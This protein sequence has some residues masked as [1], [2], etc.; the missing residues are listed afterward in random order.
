MMLDEII[1]YV[2][3]LQNQVEFL[4]M[5]LACVNPMMF[6]LSDDYDCLVN[7]TE[8]M[9]FSLLQPTLDQ[10]TCKG[11][12]TMMNHPPVL[13][14]N[15]G[16]F[17]LSQENVSFLKQIPDERQDLILNNIVLNN[18]MCLFQHG[19]KGEGPY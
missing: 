17:F 19:S 5:K 12:E 11:Y 18:N 1:N 9:P 3:S 15:Q 4:S 10:G 2:Q 7:Q 8:L 13:L 6:D 14:Q 16:S